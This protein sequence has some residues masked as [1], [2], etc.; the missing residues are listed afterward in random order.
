MRIGIKGWS[1]SVPEVLE[2]LAGFIGMMAL[3]ALIALGFLVEIVL[4]PY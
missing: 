1:Q 3:V 4:H 2:E